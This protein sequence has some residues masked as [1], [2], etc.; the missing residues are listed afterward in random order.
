MAAHLPRFWH[1]TR[2]DRMKLIR[3][4]QLFL[5][6]AAELKTPDQLKQ[7]YY[8]A[9]MSKL[10][11]A[12]T[13][14][15]ANAWLYELFHYYRAYSFFNFDEIVNIFVDLLF[16]THK[17]NFH[18][19]ERDL[20][21]LSL[22]E[23]PDIDTKIKTYIIQRYIDNYLDK[24][25]IVDYLALETMDLPLGPE[26]YR[27]VQMSIIKGIIDMAQNQPI[28]SSSQLAHLMTYSTKLD[29]QFL[30]RLAKHLGP[31]YYAKVMENQSGKHVPI[32]NEMESK[33]KLT[34]YDI[35]RL[36]NSKSE[37]IGRKRFMTWMID[38]ADEKG[39]NYL[40]TFLYQGDGDQYFMLDEQ[41]K[42]MDTNYNII[43]WPQQIKPILHWSTLPQE[44][45]DKWSNMFADFKIVPNT[46][47]GS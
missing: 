15:D 2:G 25:D 42:P 27:K 3:Q 20:H 24:I 39:K 8:N 41:M 33:E 4:A 18:N 23:I 16:S 35:A 26:Y 36:F 19:I 47:F 37:G 6:M 32:K 1:Y 17:F 10:K 30:L 22:S 14:G 44:I 40:R 9:A 46:N 34:S 7:Q 28:M 31:D 21:Y 11:S 12:T 13:I 38:K 45:Q 5:L 29:K 43:K